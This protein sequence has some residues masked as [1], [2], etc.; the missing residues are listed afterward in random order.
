MKKAAPSA[1][2]SA[3]A[4]M[5]L[6]PPDQSSLWKAVE[7]ALARVVEEAVRKAVEVIPQKAT[8]VAELPVPRADGVLL[9]PNETAQLVRLGLRTVQRMV[10]AGTFVQPVMVDPPRPRWRLEDIQE[11]LKKKRRKGRKA[12]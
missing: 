5:I 6:T 12:S 9:T 8:A 1:A 3:R 7:E 2:P 11:W 4:E 10:A